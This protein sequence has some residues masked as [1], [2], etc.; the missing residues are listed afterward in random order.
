M[1]QLTL[2]TKAAQMAAKTYEHVMNR[3]EIGVPQRAQY[4]CCG[5]ASADSTAYVRSFSRTSLEPTY[6]TRS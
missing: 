5:A 1:R 6:G 4:T 2:K 3:Q